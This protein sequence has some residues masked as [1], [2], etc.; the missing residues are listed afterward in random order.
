MIPER[1][2][3]ICREA[4]TSD[5][6]LEEQ[7]IV[8]KLPSFFLLDL[9]DTILDY[10][11]TGI[12]CWESLCTSYAHR[13]GDV[14]PKELLIALDQS[15]RWFWSDAERHRRGRLDLKGARREIVARTLGQLRIEKRRIG[16]ELADSFTAM[17][18]E[19]VHP[20]PG[21]LETLRILQSKGIRM[22]LI[23]N[24]RSEFQRGKIHRFDLEQFFELV[25]IESEFG[26]GKPDPRVF[27]FGLEQLG[28]SAH[29]AW[30]I[31]DDL[32]LDIRP[33]QELGMDTVWV[34]RAGAPTASDEAVM[35]THT[36]RSLA[37]LLE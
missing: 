27:R 6:S 35:P 3:Q 25:L 16:D 11:S 29:Q 28:A 1:W 15:R 9:D 4:D 14:S 36:I 17:R 2:S 22:G 7:L 24:G 37:D 31:G 33:A 30:M 10:T 13:L 18:E 5:G 23:T 32:E 19:M 20:F 12:H 21:A 26:V 8:K 34:D